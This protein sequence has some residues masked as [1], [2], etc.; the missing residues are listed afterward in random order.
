MLDGGP[1][2]NVVIQG[3]AAPAIGRREC[4]AVLGQFMASSFVP[5]G[6]GHGATPIADPQ[7]SQ[8]PVLAMPQHA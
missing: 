2:N 3:F 1:G 4:R 5:A 8:P 7:A 6:Q